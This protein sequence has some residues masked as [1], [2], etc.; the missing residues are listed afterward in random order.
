MT[1]VTNKMKTKNRHGEVPDNVSI[2]KKKHQFAKVSKVVL[3]IM[4]Q[5]WW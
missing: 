5:W 1:Q 3:M 4:K 2:L